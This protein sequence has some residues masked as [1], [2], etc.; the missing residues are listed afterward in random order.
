[1]NPNYPPKNCIHCNAPLNAGARFCNQCGAP[2]EGI[3]PTQKVE[4]PQPGYQEPAPTVYAEDFV[5]PYPAA[6]ERKRSNRAIVLL[7]VFGIS[8]VCFC[9][10]AGLVVGY[11]VFSADGDE[12]PTPLAVQPTV[13]PVITETLAPAPTEAPTSEAPPSP[14]PSGSEV[15][16]GQVQFFYDP[17]LVQNVIP[18][19]VPESNYA[20]APPFDLHPQHVRFT[21]DGY[22]LY[23]DA[24]HTPQI[25]V[26]PAPEYA[27]LNP[28]AADEISNL[29]NLL[30][31]PHL[32]LRSHPQHPF[33]PN[34]RS[35]QRSLRS[36]R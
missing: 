36:I 19:T 27:A 15:A 16:Y 2:I 31:R 10:S 13:A 14:M 26:Y 4:D 30:C 34:R 11:L 6:P 12:A 8:L 25:M 28:S 7:A 21:F 3:P 18:E 17:N 9:I 29:G 1:M 24:F 33:L 20:D 32:S 23:P 22:P 35:H 5:P